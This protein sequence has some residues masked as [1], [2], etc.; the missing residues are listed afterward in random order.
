[1]ASQPSLQIQKI[2]SGP[3]VTQRNRPTL[4][5]E[6]R[7]YSVDAPDLLWLFCGFRNELTL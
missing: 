4:Q 2:V 3:G 7:A 5:A 6:G 1:M